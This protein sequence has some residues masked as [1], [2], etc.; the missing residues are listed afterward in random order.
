MGIHDFMAAY[1]RVW[2]AQDSP[3]FA[4][5]FADD[6]VYHNTPFAVQQGRDQLIAYWDRIL[7]QRDITLNYKVLAETPNG[8]I[9]HWN[10]VYQVASE[11]LFQIWAASTGTG[12]PD[13]KPGDPLPRMELDGMLT[14][15]FDD[16][17]KAREVSI[18]WH[19]IPHPQ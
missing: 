4:D 12:L 17:G 7:L 8:G 13:R 2:E 15:E 18:W 19:S 16:T 10:V 11:E 5:L 9:G 6:S 1:K 14:A 3:G